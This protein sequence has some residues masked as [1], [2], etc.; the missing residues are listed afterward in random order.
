MKSSDLLGK[1]AAALAS[2]SLVFKSD[3]SKFADDLLQAAKD[4]YALGKV[5][6]G[7]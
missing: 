7:G 1:V 6:P 3:D 2:S 4:L 5:N